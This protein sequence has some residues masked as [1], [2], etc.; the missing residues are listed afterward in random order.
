MQPR[1]IHTH[2]HV[3]GL[4]GS[5]GETQQCLCQ[6]QISHVSLLQ[7]TDRSSVGCNPLHEGQVHARQGGKQGGRKGPEEWERSASFL[8]LC[9]FPSPHGSIFPSALLLSSP[10]L[11]RGIQSLHWEGSALKVI[12]NCAARCLLS[13]PYLP[14]YPSCHPIYPPPSAPTLQPSGGLDSAQLRETMLQIPVRA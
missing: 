7:A 3:P 11:H 9:T 6:G 14:P 10:S 5:S 1:P 2:T 13:P 12:Q 4:K 8:S